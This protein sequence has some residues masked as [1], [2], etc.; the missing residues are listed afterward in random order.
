MKPTPPT[1]L[2]AACFVAAVSLVAAGCKPPPTMGHGSG[3]GSIS[4]GGGSNIADDSLIVRSNPSLGGSP[5]PA[6]AKPGL[7]LT[8]RWGAATIPGEGTDFQEDPQGGW[9]DKNGKHYAPLDNKGGSGGGGYAETIVV[10]MDDEV[11][12]LSTNSYGFVV[13]DVP[14][15][16]MRIP[17]GGQAGFAGGAWASPD[18]LNQLQTNMG[19]SLDIMNMPY[20]SPNGKVEAVWIKTKGTQSYECS[21]YDKSTG[22]MIHDGSAGTSAVSPV[23]AQGESNTGNLM[24]T[25]TTL[26]KVDTINVPWAQDPAPDWTRNV[27]SLAYEGVSHMAAGMDIP[28]SVK[29]SVEVVKQDHGCTLFKGTQ[30]VVVGNSNMPIVTPSMFV[31][32]PYDFAPVWIPPSGLARLQ[33]GQVLDTNTITQVTTKV[34]GHQRGQKGDMVVIEQANG[35]GGVDRAYDANTGLMVEFRVVDNSIHSDA[36]LQLVSQS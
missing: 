16:L 9:V 14:K 15:F 27:H 8:Y 22:L 20:D 25:D 2:A 23:H 1:E 31:T 12:A 24:L 30:S 32:G 21:V 29:Y 7:R 5:P 13:S 34:I 36:T 28:S 6:I 35:A 3:P 18:L 33:Q 17:A 4:M 11:A 10:G 19:P 26:L